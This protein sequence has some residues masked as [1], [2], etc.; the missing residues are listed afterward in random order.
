ML[1]SAGVRS[2][3]GARARDGKG[4]VGRARRRLPLASDSSCSMA[5]AA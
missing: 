2:I 4:A 1:E 3:V 5:E